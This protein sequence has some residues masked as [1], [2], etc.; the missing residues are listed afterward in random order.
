MGVCCC[1]CCADVPVASNTPESVIKNAIRRTERTP[2]LFRGRVVPGSSEN[3]ERRKPL[4]RP[5]LDF[6]LSPRA[7]VLLVCRLISEDILVSKLHPD[8]IGN[9]GQLA[10][11]SYR[12]A[13]PTGNLRHFRKQRRPVQLFVGPRP[14][15][16]RI[17]NADCIELAIGFL[18]VVLYVVLIVP[19]MIISSVG[20]DEQGSFGVVCTPHL[21]S[22]QV[23]RIEQCS[24]SG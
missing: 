15:A 18:P 21:A 17:E 1:C 11:I 16:D 4:G 6:D 23:V 8:L 13:P 5:Q 12:K 24:A 2:R 19:A 10:Y 22:T 3:I 9:V 20:Y 7:V 14:N